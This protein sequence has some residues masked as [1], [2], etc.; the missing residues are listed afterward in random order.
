MVGGTGQDHE[1]VVRWP[2]SRAHHRTPRS[3][4]S[5][6]FSSSGRASRASTPPTASSSA[7]PGRVTP[8]WSAGSAS[9]GPGICSG[10]RASVPTATSSPS[11][12]PTNRGP[13]AS[14]SPTAPISASTSPR[15]R[16][17][18]ASTGISGSTPGY[19]RRTGIPR[20]IPG[21]CTRKP[22]VPRSPTGAGS[23]SSAPAT[24]TTTRRTP[25]TFP[26]SRRSPGPSSIRSSG[27]RTSI[28][29][30]SGSS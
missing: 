18:T 3:R 6:M 23:C 19:R 9:V 29:P 15:R 22:M 24:T 16:T 14:M 1:E 13:V 12:I 30:V 4:S 28:T 7:T 11:A 2:M 17:N 26:V 5:A 10:I 8:S 21:P 27:Q 20:P 25:R